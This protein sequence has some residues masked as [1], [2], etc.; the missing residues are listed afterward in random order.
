M[1]VNLPNL[2]SIGRLL[3]APVIVLLVLS[4][5]MLAAFWLFVG[6][7]VSDGVDGYIAKRF[8][9]VTRV[10]AYLDPVADKVLLV[11]V[12]ITMGQEGLLPVWLVIAVVSR[13]LL[14]V[15]GLL[16]TLIIGQSVAIR[17]LLLSKINTTA[18]IALAAAVLGFS[19]YGASVPVLI[20]A[21]IY[22][23]A[24]T[25]IVSG[26]Q[27]MVQWVKITATGEV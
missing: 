22:L 16:F 19:A 15:G 20:V 26:A 10:G 8:D 9:V 21:L 5:H 27:Y 14:I 18:Q 1:I 23:V 2:I 25:T 12:Y 24:G 4:G 3:S 11:S 6:A 7:G 13:D 17:P